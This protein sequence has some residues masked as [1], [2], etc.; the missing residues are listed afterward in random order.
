[1][2]PRRSFL[3][4]PLNVP[5][6]SGTYIHR[7]P[8]PLHCSLTA[9]KLLANSVHAFVLCSTL[10]LFRCFGDQQKTRVPQ[11]RSRDPSTA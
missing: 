10:L 9:Q 2:H 4:A 8:N 5:Y 6:F 1:L 7:S 3:S 11:R